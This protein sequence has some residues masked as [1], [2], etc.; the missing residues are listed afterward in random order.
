ML[1]DLRHAVRVLLQA[2]GWSAVILLSLALGIGANTAIFSALNGLLLTH[3][4]VREP[5]TLV[6]FRYSGRNDMVTSSSDYG[7]TA[8]GPDGQ[9]V[10]TTF[11]YAMYQQLAAESR[12][13]LGDM[14]A[15]APY[16]RVNVVFKEQAEIASAFISTG[17]YYRMLGVNARLGRTL[18]PDDDR[19]DAPPAAVISSKY[20]HKR[21]ATDPAVVGKTIQI[22]NVL[23][24]IVGVI[25]PGFT[26]IQQPLAELHDI[27]VPLSL[28]PQLNTLTA[29]GQPA[30]T[31]RISQPT[32][33]WLQVMGRLKAGVTAAQV[34]GQLERVFQ[35]TARAGLDSYLQTLSESDRGLAR[36]RNRTE[37][38]RLKVEPG[39]RGIYDVNTNELRAATVLSIVVGLVLLI[40]CVNVANLLL[41]RAATRYNE[42]SIRRSLGATRWRLV[43]QL[44]TESLLLASLG[45]ALGTLVGYWGRQL[46]P[47]PAAQA[48]LLDLRVLAF[49]LGVTFITGLAFGIAPALRAT[50]GEL[51]SALKH[52]GRGVVSSR[53]LLARSLVMVQVAISLVLLV[54]AG[55][56]LRTLHNLQRVDV[57]FDPQNLLLF[58]LTPQLNRYDDARSLAMLRDVQQRI[59]AVPGVRGVAV[60]NPAL[61]SG[62]VNSTSVYVQGHTYANPRDSRQSINRLVVSANFFEVLGIPIVAGR[63]FSERDHQTA[64]KVAVINETAAKRFFH[65]AAPI[66][67]RFGSSYEQSGE[68]EIVG[69]ARDAKY[70]SVR[71]DVPPT[72][73]VPYVQSR[74]FGAV[75]AVRTAANPASATGA[76]REAVRQIDP[77]VPMMD[78]STQLEQIDRRF[79]Q[80]RMFAQAYGMFG[81]LA[82][83]L[84]A[85]GLFGLMSYNVARR[86]NE[87]G[88]RMALGAEKRDVLRMV[89]AESL[90]LVVMGIVVGVGAA[91]GIGHLVTTLLYGLAPTDPTTIAGAVAVMALVSTLAGWL[92]ARRA[93]RVEPIVALRYE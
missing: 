76:V 14:L 33:W 40:V 44:L 7:F 11:S 29:P 73:Y 13:L 27:G 71:D 74:L 86:T 82:L 26:G 38:P 70:D 92:P 9:G 77:N 35:Q 60:L 49:V 55:L 79:Q 28:E 10:R 84:A 2:K 24:S 65:T 42:L 54:G 19:A 50:G 31:S 64:P 16:G 78:I 88:V 52:A 83:L 87:I 75:V 3:I 91:L 39:Q 58:R 56:F 6:R 46:L 4:P 63:G 21:F 85:I 5:E 89:L 68:L 30:S 15:C 32:Y 18:L 36:N 20:W 23:V 34:Q 51:N 8:R 47:G 90:S 72:M 67:Q 81:G 53:S 22:N 57:G 61:L 80:E 1:K 43:R 37:I 59:A 93:A 17:N 62:S 41:S 66:G 12:S 45:G 48:K 25:E 69:I